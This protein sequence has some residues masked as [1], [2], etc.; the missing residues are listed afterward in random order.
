M[1]LLSVLVCLGGLG[2]A[3]FAFLVSGRHPAAVPAGLVIFA[4]S[5]ATAWTPMGETRVGRAGLGVLMLGA[6]VALMGLLY[7]DG[8]RNPSSLMFGAMFVLAVAVLAFGFPAT[9][10]DDPF[11]WAAVAAI[12]VVLVGTATLVVAQGP[13]WLLVG[14]LALMPA[15]GL[16]VART[17]VGPVR[18]GLGVVLAAVTVMSAY[19]LAIGP[20]PLSAV[21]GVLALVALVFALRAGRPAHSADPAVGDQA[22]R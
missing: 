18:V 11:G 9:D 10:T 21:F 12:A 20:S 13:R 16:L 8:G 4:G 7:V 17:T 19:F 2:V 22:V 14:G 6:A 1:R 15:I 5:L 3:V